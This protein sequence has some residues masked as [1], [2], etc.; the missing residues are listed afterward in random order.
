MVADPAL[1]LNTVSVPIGKQTRPV[2][3]VL[4][5][6]HVAIGNIVARGLSPGSFFPAKSTLAVILFLGGSRVQLQDR[7]MSD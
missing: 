2:S 4:T 6:Y 1:C 5:P 7:E 3:F